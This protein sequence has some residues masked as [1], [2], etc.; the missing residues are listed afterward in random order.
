[1]T[2]FVARDCGSKVENEKLFHEEGRPE[3]NLYVTPASHSST[4][5][6]F[7]SILR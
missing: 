7:H 4:L 5:E 1:M 3:R 6:L 2:V